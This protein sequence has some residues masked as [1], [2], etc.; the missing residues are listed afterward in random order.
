MNTL[1]AYWNVLRYEYRV[2]DPT[3]KLLLAGS[4]V[5]MIVGFIATPFLVI[6]SLNTLFNLGIQYNVWTLL[7]ALYLA[8][9]VSG[10][11]KSKKG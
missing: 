10:G 2:A 4:F 3:V 11:V 6:A 8:L 5:L 7:S 1:I 9:L